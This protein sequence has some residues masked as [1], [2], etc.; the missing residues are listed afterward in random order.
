MKKLLV[1][2]VIMVIVVGAVVPVLARAGTA[3]ACTEGL[4]PGYWKNHIEAWEGWG[5]NACFN[6]VFGV[7]PH[8]RLIDVLN[9]GGGK[10]DALNRHAVAALLNATSDLDFHSYD[11]VINNV[12]AAYSSGNWGYYKSLLEDANE[13]GVAG[14]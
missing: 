4:T 11:W 6:H 9:T 8:Q 14:D 3:A 12:R 10:W 13:M 2:I 1:I 5:P 7:G